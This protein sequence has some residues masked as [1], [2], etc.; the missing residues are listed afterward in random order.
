MSRPWFVIEPHRRFD[1]LGPQPPFERK[2]GSGIHE[3]TEG[4]PT[5]IVYSRLARAGISVDT[6]VG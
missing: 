3:L 6:L 1:V 2:I 4:E 5:T